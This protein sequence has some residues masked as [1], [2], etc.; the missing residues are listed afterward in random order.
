MSNAE[1]TTGRS[2]GRVVGLWSENRIAEVSRAYYGNRKSVEL[3]LAAL[4]CRGHVLIEDLP[5]VGK[6]LLARS[7]AAA[8]GGRFRQIQ[9]TP[10]LLPSDILGVS[11]YH[12]ST[13]SFRF[14][15][16]PV[17]TNTLLV[18]EINRATPR[19][20]SALLEAMAEG[21]ISIESR[22][23]KLPSPFFLIATQSPL[24]SEGTFPLPEVQKDRFFLSLKL[25]YPDRFD[26]ARILADWSEAKLPDDEGKQESAL[27]VSEMQE[28]VTEV[29]VSEGIKDYVLALIAQT[30]RDPRLVVG[31]SPRGS[32]ALFKG[33]QAIAA[34]AGR[35]WVSPE[36]VRVLVSPVLLGRLLIRPEQAARGVTPKTIVEELLST[37]EV[38]GYDGKE[39]MR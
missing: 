6:T 33:S 12:P 10:D 20:Q 36:D 30:R 7:L 28:L 31:V 8:V 32:L 35:D 18:D 38:P 3:C 17:M 25:G 27:A 14:R 2:P 22:T 15:E 4:L 16:G 26:E 11:V 34:I 19:T 24:E 1:S 37:V 21:Q 5:G 39:A 9:C 29:F 23:V 13:G